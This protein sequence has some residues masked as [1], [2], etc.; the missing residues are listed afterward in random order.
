MSHLN[1]KLLGLGT[2]AAVV[3]LSAFVPNP[4]MIGEAM[5]QATAQDTMNIT[6]KVVNPLN[7]LQLTK[8]DMGDF[9]VSAA[10][11][12]RTVPAGGG[13]VVM[14]NGVD[15][16]GDV[17]GKVSLQAPQN[18]TFT[19]EIA[20][21]AAAAI[22]LKNGTGGTS[23][24]TM[25]V[26]QLTLNATTKMKLGGVAGGSATFVKS[27]NTNTSAVIVDAGG[28][29]IAEIGGRVLFKPTQVTGSYL[30]TYTLLTSF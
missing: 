26:D 24:K 19:I 16:G 13:A 22:V 4:F 27:G 6:A 5:A 30:G 21:L 29:G 20:A 11:G 2:G 9:A 10:S 3:A 7:V 17:L 15:L 28:V 12:K 14:S 18:A 1:K 8:F 23:K 25:K